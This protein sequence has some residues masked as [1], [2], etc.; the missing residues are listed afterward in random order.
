[1]VKEETLHRSSKPNGYDVQ[2]FMPLK[3]YM[4][5]L[6]VEMFYACSSAREWLGMHIHLCI[7]TNLSL[8]S[9]YIKPRLLKVKMWRGHEENMDGN[10]FCCCFQC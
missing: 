9:L 1:L 5:L 8:S 4:Y 6:K 10:F 2:V 3:N 7:V